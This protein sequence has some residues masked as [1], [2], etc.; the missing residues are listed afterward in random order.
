[1][2]LVHVTKKGCCAFCG[3]KVR[4]CIVC[5]DFFHASRTTHVYCAGTCRVRAYRNKKA[6]TKPAIVEQIDLLPPDT[7][8]SIM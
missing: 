1:M 6:D 8:T 5:K 7:P 4:L 2:K 3:A